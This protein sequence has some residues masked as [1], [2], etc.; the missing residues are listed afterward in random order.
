MTGIVSSVGVEAADDLA[1]AH[2]ACFAKPWS[3]AAFTELMATAGTVAL[4]S[5]DKTGLAGLILIRAVEGEAEILTVAVHPQARRKGLGRKLVEVAAKTAV[6]AGAT[7]LWLE[8]GVENAAALALYAVTG[9]EAA[10]RRKGY[11][12]HADGAEDALILR[13]VLNTITA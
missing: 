7:T 3:A 1:A 10:G 6:A 4:A 8:V 5:A 12:Q 9:F 2:G 13:R 11:Y